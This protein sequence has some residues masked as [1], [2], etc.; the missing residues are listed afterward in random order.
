MERLPFGVN[1]APFI[2]NA[3]LHYHLRLQQQAAKTAT[4]TEAMELLEKLFHV[5]D[6]ISSL[7]QLADA[8]TFK[9]VSTLGLQEAGMDLRKWR[10]NEMEASL[11]MADI[12]KVFDMVCDIW[13]NVLRIVSAIVQP[14]GNELTE[15]G[16]LKCLASLP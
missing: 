15:K 3:V 2:L 14:D 11:D 13:K 4:R 16:L 6:C 10:G 8:Q 7:T 12:G 9:E 5:D 1:C